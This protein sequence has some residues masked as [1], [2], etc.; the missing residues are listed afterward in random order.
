MPKHGFQLCNEWGEK[1]HPANAIAEIKCDGMM[2]LV[3]NGRMYNRRNWDATFQFP[4]VKVHS[5]LV[6]VGEI[7]ILKEGISQFHFLQK[8]NVD[9]PKDIRLRSM[10]YPATLVAFDL[11][12]LNGQD[13]V[14]EPLSVRRKALENLEHTKALNG[15]VHVADFWGCPKE[16]VPEYLDLVR[17]M[18]GEGIIVKDLD[19]PYKASRNDAWL[20][21]KAWKEDDYD[22]LR[23]EITENGGFVVYIVNRGYEQKVVVNDRSLADEI[24]KGN[25]KR[26]RIRYLDVEASGALRQP[27]VRGV[28]RDH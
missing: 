4:E 26:L 8:R 11:L 25:V 21:L 17:S 2:V 12:E 13:L 9:S 14:D 18:N 1:K 16:K 6:L 10:L 27:H 7:V 3:E 24:A 23:H 28:P 22:V 15:S 19:A 5:N 20:K